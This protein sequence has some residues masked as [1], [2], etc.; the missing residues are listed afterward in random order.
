MA[1]ASTG[2]AG[3]MLSLHAEW[4]VSADENYD[5]KGLPAR[6]GQAAAKAFLFPSPALLAVPCDDHRR[7]TPK[8]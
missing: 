7:T 4:S 6:E 5:R 3:L 8:A 2:G 1:A